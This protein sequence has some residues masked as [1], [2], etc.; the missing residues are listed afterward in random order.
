MDTLVIVGILVPL[1]LIQVLVPKAPDGNV[2]RLE[3]KIDLILEHLGLDLNQGVHEKI[4]ELLKADK[5]IEAIK[6][7]REQTG[8]A[9][10]LIVIGMSAT[11]F[12]IADPEDS[13]MLDMVGFDASGPNIIREF[14]LGHV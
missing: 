5:K 10:K 9:A 11:Q 4:I 13:G 12:S 6:F 8:V 7:Y 14:L 3:R 2:L 1:L